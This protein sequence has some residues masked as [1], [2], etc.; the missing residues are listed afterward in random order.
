MR[1][2]S[3]RCK[4]GIGLALAV[5]IP[6]AWAANGLDP[7]FRAALERAGW[8][9][10]RSN[11]GS[12]ILRPSPG[13]GPETPSAP[14]TPLAESDPDRWAPL[15]DAGWRVEIG[16]DGSTFLYP[17][18]KEPAAEAPI[19]QKP[20][21]STEP[22]VKR[23]MAERGWRVERLPDGSVILRPQ[24]RKTAPAEV[25]PAPGYVPGV[26][27]DAVVTPPVDQWAEARRIAYDWLAVFGNDTMTVGRIRKI[28]RVYLV[29]VV[30]KAPPHRLVHQ[31][32]IN[33]ADGRVVL[34]N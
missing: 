11:D 2:A 31:L 22:D 24:V 19:A 30:E 27:R 33:A 6:L 32:A 34:L 7:G 4:L 26:I 17:P 5:P 20:A 15:R 18:A 28:L 25:V 10:Q 8:E 23:L 21:P 29:S 13:P 16:E 3:I 14:A 9:V 1:H 12:L